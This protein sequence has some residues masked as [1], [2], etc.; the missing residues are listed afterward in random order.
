MEAQN[1]LYAVR[2]AIII[3]KMEELQQEVCLHDCEQRFS[4]AVLHENAS[5]DDALELSTI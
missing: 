5:P 3:G 4:D 2:G 1:L